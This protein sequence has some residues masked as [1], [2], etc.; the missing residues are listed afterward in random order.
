MANTNEGWETRESRGQV[1]RR[2]LQEARRVNVREC[3]GG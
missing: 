1:A 3:R 2:L